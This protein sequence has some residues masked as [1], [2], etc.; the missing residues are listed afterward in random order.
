MDFNA[1]CVLRHTMTPVGLNLTEE[2]FTLSEFQSLFQET[3]KVHSQF[4]W[5]VCDLLLYG[6]DRWNEMLDDIVIECGFSKSTYRHYHRVAKAFPTHKNRIADLSFT[7]HRLVA[8]MPPQMCRDTLKLTL[9]KGWNCAQLEAHISEDNNVRDPC[10]EFL[11]P[12]Q[13]TQV[14][15][16]AK[17]FQTTPRE[18]V[19][20]I[21]L[22]KA[23]G[24]QCPGCGFDLSEMWSG[25]ADP[26]T[27]QP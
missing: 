8:S 23:C 13:R 2:T 9:K 1:R 4:Q 3:G 20:A 14:T 10:L 6:A 12:V 11:T 21:E 15:Q 25:Q 26:K 19:T 7:H 22:V 16:I 5:A 27:E 17:A 24:P 18:I